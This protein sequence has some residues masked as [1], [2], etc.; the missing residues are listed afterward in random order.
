MEVQIDRQ[1]DRQT[2]R[3]TDRQPHKQTNRQTDRQTDRQTA[4]QTHRKTDRQTSRQTGRQTDRQTDRQRERETDRQADRQTDTQT[5]RQIDP[6][7]FPLTLSDHANTNVCNILNAS[8]RPY[9]HI[10][11][12]KLRQEYDASIIKAAWKHKTSGKC[13]HGMPVSGH[14]A[15][16]Q[17]SLKSELAKTVKA[18]REMRYLHFGSPKRCQRLRKYVS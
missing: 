15:S 1:T 17:K 9:V 4:T 14:L 11:A 8:N 12:F 16:S 3:R 5:D 18:R 13:F 10:D 7:M 2:D 6:G